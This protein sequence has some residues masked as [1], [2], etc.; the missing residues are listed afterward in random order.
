MVERDAR[1]PKGKY[2]QIVAEPPCHARLWRDWAIR[3]GKKGDE[4]AEGDSR[5]DRW[6]SGWG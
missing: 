4:E 1:W 2:R 6:G 3:E 5:G